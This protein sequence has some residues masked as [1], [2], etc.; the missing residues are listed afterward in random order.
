MT[1]P[2]GLRVSDLDTPALVIDLDVM[3]RNLRKLADYGREH[4]LRIRPHTKTHKIPALARKQIDL[5]AAGLTV[6]K[7][8]EAEVMLS[9][10]PPAFLVVSHDMSFLTTTCEHLVWLEKGV[11][12]AQGEPATVGREGLIACSDRAARA[13]TSYHSPI[14]SAVRPGAEKTASVKPLWFE[15]GQT[16]PANRTSLIPWLTSVARFAVL[17]FRPESSDWG[18]FPPS[19]LGM[20]TSRSG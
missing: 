17:Q 6:A 10:D 9:A 19:I 12:R 5:G 2:T 16:P 20:R 1:A 15:S 14:H 11:V 3:E 4:D 8:G 13:P 7:V 18:A